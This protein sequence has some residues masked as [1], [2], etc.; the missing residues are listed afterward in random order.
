[1][2]LLLHTCCGPCFLMPYDSLKDDH[3]ISVYY[4]NPNI[5]TK[6]EYKRRQSVAKDHIESKDVPFI[7]VEYDQLE[8][9]EAV[10]SDTSR[11]HR[12]KSCYRLRLKKAA[13]Y[14]KRHGFD[15][16]TTTLLVSPYQFHDELNDIGVSVGKTMGVDFL[17]R[18][19]RPFYK[20][21]VTISRDLGMYRQNYC[22]CRF[23]LLEKEEETAK[24]AQL[25]KM[26][27]R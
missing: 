22:G 7:E 16:F 10:A 23:S 4:Y 17:Y 20:D 9:N 25:G 26:I 18:D 15:A 8:Y 2:K 21:C 13:L 5:N 11:P 3:D 27:G 6:E 1:M 14:A 19:F 12:C 24:K